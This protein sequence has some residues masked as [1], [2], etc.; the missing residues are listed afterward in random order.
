[1]R[2]KKMKI[3]NSEGQY[4]YKVEDLPVWEVGVLWYNHVDD[5][6]INSWR[7]FFDNEEDAR[8]KDK[9]IKEYWKE[10]RDTGWNTPYEHLWCQQIWVCKE[11]KKIK[12]R[13]IN[14]GITT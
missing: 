5:D 3:W 1:M 4:E 14:K 8:K 6:Y 7:W 13:K 2:K 12:E 10:P 11:P 9:H